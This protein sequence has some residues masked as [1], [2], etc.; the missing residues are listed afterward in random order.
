MENVERNT[1][2]EETTIHTQGGTNGQQCYHVAKP[3]SS[4]VDAKFIIIFFSLYIGLVILGE[5]F[6]FAFRESNYQNQF[7]M[8][9]IPSVG[10]LKTVSMG[11]LPLAIK[12]KKLRIIGFIL[13]GAII[14]L[15]VA[16][17]T[18]LLLTAFYQK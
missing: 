12:D 7:M 15:P 9:A 10:L 18:I 16:F 4:S 1:Q 3:N 2:C 11:L 13:F 14:L 17:G 6:N 5:L 8:K